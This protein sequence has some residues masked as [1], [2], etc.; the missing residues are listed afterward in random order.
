MELPK[1][2]KDEDECHVFRQIEAVTALRY[3][4]ACHELHREKV[5][6]KYIFCLPLFVLAFFG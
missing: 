2:S 4:P 3:V 1:H 6:L 5:S